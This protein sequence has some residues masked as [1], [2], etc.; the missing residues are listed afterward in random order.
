MSGSEAAHRD[1][2]LP[3][4][5][6]SCESIVALVDRACR[7][8][9]DLPALI[10]EDGLVVTRQ[11]FLDQ[12]ERFAGYLAA[13]T[14]PGD[15]IAVMLDTRAEFMIAL[16][17]ALAVRCVLVPMNPTA[18][19]HDA[20]HVL[21]DS[22]A[23]IA[24]VGSPNKSLLDRL[25]KECPLLREIVVVQDPEPAGLA[26]YGADTEV[27]RLAHCAAVRRDIATIH[28]TS[29]TT[30]PPK[31]CMLDHEWW[32]RVCDVHLR[33]TPHRPDDRHLCCVPFYYVDSLF[34]LLCILHA[35]EA[36]VVMRRF[37]VSRFWQ[38]AHDHHATL[39]YL[40]A[41]MPILLLKQAPSKLER[42][43]RLRLAVCLAVPAGLHR[44][45]VDRFG[46][47]FLDGYGST[48]AGW[49]TRVP[50]DRAEAS[51]GSGSMG[52][53]V[54]ECDLRVV[55]EAD[56]DLPVGRE[57]ELLIRAPG[58]FAGY[59]NQPEATAAAMRGGWYH[60]GDVVRADARGF[61]YFVGRRKDIVRRGGENVACAEVEAVLRTH[62]KI[63]D[64]AVIPVPDE[65]RG[66]EVKAYVQLLEGCA[67]DELP[68]DEIVAY[69][70]SR[71]AA[72]KV[73]RYVAYQAADFPRTPS[74]RIRKEELKAAPDLT[75]DAWDRERGGWPSRPSRWAAPSASV[76]Q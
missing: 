24:I 38:V 15:R 11:Q 52:A 70:A 62:P 40:I 45:L 9:P 50:T 47:P 68:P 39:V 28:Y 63:R 2:G 67:A 59:L 22:G 41:S 73:P 66:E 64:A 10:F 3:W 7:R 49:V 1:C 30:G 17:A 58:L 35:G 4:S 20:G 44:E 8:A 12:A 46:V 76:K 21:R 54:P 23:A 69:C 25:K 53:A 56:R 33:L 65:I 72:F 19:E 51:I 74:M 60:T 34:P 43:H 13:R 36:V 75:A 18:G 29:G 14:A 61:F 31:G 27:V 55:D 32:L 37:S 48:E 26:A 6:V 5:A 16:M 42:R 57:G 71:L